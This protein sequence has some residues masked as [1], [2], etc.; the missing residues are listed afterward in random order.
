[1]S[2]C[3]FSTDDYQCDFYVFEA[4]HGGFSLSLA[5]KRYILNNIPAVVSMDNVEKWVDRHKL[6]MSMVKVANVI[7]IDLPYAGEMFSYDTIEELLVALIDFKAMGYRCPD[8]VIENVRHD[9]VKV[10]AKAT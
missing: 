3:R 10:I 9:C 5:K 2:Y 6:I 7:D 1:M 4:C 8:Y